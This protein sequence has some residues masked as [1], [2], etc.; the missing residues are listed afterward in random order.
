[1]GLRIGVDV[2]GTFTDLCLFDDRSKLLSIAKVPSTPNSPDQGVLEGVRRILADTQCRPEDVEFFVHGT[3][4]ATNAIIEYKG[5]KVGLLV[6][7]GFR[8]V[9]QIVRQDRPKLYDYFAQHAKPLVPRSHTYEV[10]ER[11]LFDGQIRT[12][13]DE[14]RTRKLLRQIKKKGEVEILAVCLL[15]AYANPVHELRIR[16][17]I[18]EELP[19]MK[20]SLSSEIL[21]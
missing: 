7:E 12:G 6:T 2:G 13:L 21:P 14:G 15:H 19:G 8:D 11:M 17:L 20:V 18:N 16:E 5:A 1:M 3:T 4:I 9:L 10:R